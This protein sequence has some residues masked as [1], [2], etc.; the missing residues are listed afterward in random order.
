[1]GNEAYPGPIDLE[2]S[3]EER[4][5]VTNEQ[6]KL[7]WS[8]ASVGSLVATAFAFVM[9][10]QFR[11]VVSPAWLVGWLVLK[12]AVVAPRS[13]MASVYKRRGFPHGD[14][15]RV[16]TYWLLGLD[17]IVFGIAG[18]WLMRF[19][20]TTM[21]MA[22]ASLGC[23]ACVA[24][25]GF[26]ASKRAT[27]AYAAPIIAPMVLGL[28]LRGDATGLYYAVG[29]SMLLASILISVGRTD[30]K[31][32]EV[33]ELRIHAAKVSAER[34]HALELVRRESAAKTQFL[35]TVS[36]ELRTPIHGMLGVARLTHVEATDPLTRKRMELI[37][38]SGT[39]LL[40][41]VTDLIDVSRLE[42][43]Q[44]KVTRVSFDL[45]DEV[46]RIADIY[47]VRAAEKGLAFTLDSSLPATAWIIG[48]PV[49]T[50]QV[51]HNLLGNAIKFTREGWVQLSVALDVPAG[52]VRFRVRDTGVGIAPSEQRAVFDAFHQVDGALSSNRQGTGLGLTIAR[53]IAGLLGG[54]ITLVSEP[55]FGSIFEFTIAAEP[56]APPR[57]IEAPAEANA[58]FAPALGARIL[59]AEDNDVNF[60]IASSMLASEGHQ[61]ERATNGEEAVRKALREIDRPDLI[62]MDCMMPGM[63]GLDA[64]R[65]I[66][67]QERAMDLRP[68]PIIALSALTDES[69]M[70][71][72]LECG[73]DDALGKPFAADDLLRTIRPWLALRESERNGDLLGVPRSGDFD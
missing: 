1:M 21:S 56:T 73:M 18:F 55:D 25:F 52:K 49:R 24:A 40:R 60:L 15:W 63:D 48:D 71:Q 23:V 33:F 30:A 20:V 39:H 36:H 50:R 38:T 70:Q 19:D 11:D 5:R 10:Y 47:A 7:V 45:S 12:V 59:L 9:A 37:E 51:L 61:V 44:M 28:L 67:T 64:T 3:Q 53:E 57:V 17:G 35:G 32:R 41:L 29:L 2:L 69:T 54:D 58:S 22:I 16:P 27:A 43:G 4:G 31:M 65:S 46:N 72:A 6:L 34:A 42:S 14:A 68:V 62:L 26:Q 8:H 66:R 13:V